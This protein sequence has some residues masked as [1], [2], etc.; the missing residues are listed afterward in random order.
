MS[1][2][3]V[4]CSWRPSVCCRHVL[5][6]HTALLLPGKAG[7]ALEKLF[8]HPGGTKLAENLKTVPYPAHCTFQLTQ[9][10]VATTSTRITGASIIDIPTPSPVIPLCL[11]PECTLLTW[12]I[13]LTMLLYKEAAFLHFSLP[14]PLPPPAAPLPFSN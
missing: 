10:S 14:S 5:F 11:Y 4:G 12:P 7:T 2:L 1:L 9:G 3:Q 6:L 8:T 13:S